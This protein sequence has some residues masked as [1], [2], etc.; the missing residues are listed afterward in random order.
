MQ[1]AKYELTKVLREKLYILAHPVITSHLPNRHNKYLND[2]QLEESTW[3]LYSHIVL[4]KNGDNTNLIA[5]RINSSLP[6][7]EHFGF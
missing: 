5:E 2:T 1:R 7:E 6:N 4:A 3:K